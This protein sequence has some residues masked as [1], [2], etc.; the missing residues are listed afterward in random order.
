MHVRD[1]PVGRQQQFRDV[2]LEVELL[3]A[4]RALEHAGHFLAERKPAQMQQQRFAIADG[5][6]PRD[7]RR[8]PSTRVRGEQRQRAS[9]AVVRA[10]GD[11]RAPLLQQEVLVAS[12]KRPQHGVAPPVSFQADASRQ[13]DIGEIHA[14]LPDHRFELRRLRLGHADVALPALV[15]DLDVLDEHRIGIGVEI[16]RRLI[17]G[18][19]TAEH[20]IGDDLLSRLV[21]HVDDDVLAE[22]GQ[23][24]FGARDR[25]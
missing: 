23:R 12:G 15:L 25:R 5:Q 14:L 22:I 24:R 17:F 18:N 8:D 3:G 7:V 1:L 4:G 6:R 11:K 13:L 2:Q 19:P 21:E 16:R 9:T 10:A 20:V